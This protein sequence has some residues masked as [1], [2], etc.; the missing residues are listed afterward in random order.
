MSLR[1]P[2][3][4]ASLLTGVV[5]LSAHP[6]EPPPPAWHLLQRA[7]RVHGHR[8][9]WDRVRDLRVVLERRW[10]DE[11]GRVVTR[12]DETVRLLK[13]RRARVLLET[14]TADGWRVF[15]LDGR[16]SWAT[17]NGYRWRG[18]AVWADAEER[19]RQ[20]ALLFRLPFLFRE[21][22]ARSE[23][24]G[25]GVMD[26]HHCVKV[27]VHFVGGTWDSESTFVAW[28]DATDY[29]LR[30]LEFGDR[31]TPGAR[32]Q[33]DFTRFSRVGD[34]LIPFVRRWA[35]S[36]GRYWKEEELAGVACNEDPPEHLF[37]NPIRLPEYR[38][39]AEAVDATTPP[40]DPGGVG[41]GGGL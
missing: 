36:D 31:R 19:T 23:V 25:P 21:K 20:A 29:R 13:G 27:A 4:V 33:V 38:P 8:K 24:I 17:L 18:E 3:A 22:D 32:H 16:R 5:A 39:V 37:A 35:R 15:G 28:L 14:P 12:E 7:A 2:L 10:L 1:R 26:G 40:G 30:R 6:W 34:L 41:L 11:A 9:N